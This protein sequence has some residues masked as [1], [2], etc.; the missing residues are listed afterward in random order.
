[1]LFYMTKVILQMSLSYK[2]GGYPGLSRQTQCDHRALKVKERGRRE[3]GDN[4]NRG[5][6]D[7]VD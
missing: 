5:H 7:G 1:M 3:K 4:E 6:H 2:W